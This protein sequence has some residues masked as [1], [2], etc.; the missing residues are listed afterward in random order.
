[1]GL[2]V[3]TACFTV[4]FATDLEL[5]HINAIDKNSAGD[6]LVSA[7]HTNTIYKVAG[8]NGSILWQLG[9][10]A[11]TASDFTLATGFNFSSQHDVRFVSENATTTVISIF[12][13]ASNGY[14][15]SQTSSYSSGM[16]IAIDHTTSSASLLERYICPRDQI[17]P[18]QGNTQI[19]PNGNV[20]LGW[21]SVAW[22][23][24]HTHDGNPVL[25]AYFATVGTLNYRA[26]KFNWTA[27][28][29][30]TPAAYVYAHD[31]KSQTT[32]YM[33]W[34]GATEVVKWRIYTSSDPTMAFKQIAEIDKDGFET[35][36]TAAKYQAWS[37]IEAVAA[38]GSGLANSS[39][40]VQTFVPSA[41]LA[42]ACTDSQ[43]P[44]A[45]GYSSQWKPSTTP[46]SPPPKS[47]AKKGDAAA[48]AMSLHIWELSA[49]VVVAAI[50]W[51]L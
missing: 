20:F 23:S 37:I 25:Q 17:S 24:E 44:V 41:A 12:D 32:Y 45:Q 19:L 38:N 48:L 6:Y 39:S 42:D 28:P 46:D 2:L 50:F 1:M 30:D 29:T 51:S 33:S 10:T 3:C 8:T 13:N 16:I 26:Y 47:T 22:I 40:Y 14:A 15:H 4:Q 35:I 43:C 21:G 7:R 11:A 36:Y 5:S 49:F 31:I 9:G 34:N 27:T 18:S